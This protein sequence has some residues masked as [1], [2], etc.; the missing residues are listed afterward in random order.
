MV[1]DVFVVVG[2]DYGDFKIVVG[3]GWENIG[4]LEWVRWDIGLI[5]DIVILMYFD[6]CIGSGLFVYYWC[7]IMFVVG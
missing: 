1:C 7:V 2:F 5:E 6:Y 3:V 4:E